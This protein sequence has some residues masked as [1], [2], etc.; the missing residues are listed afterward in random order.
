[1][2]AGS[3]LRAFDSLAVEQYQERLNLREK[4]CRGRQPQLY[5][6][7]ARYLLVDMTS[8]GQSGKGVSCDTQLS[9]N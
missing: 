2:V 9:L 5:S 4:H 6:Q 1:M 7:T 3:C 8:S